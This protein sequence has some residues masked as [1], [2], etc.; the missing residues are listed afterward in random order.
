M[1]TGQPDALAPLRDAL[2]STGYEVDLRCGPAGMAD[3]DLAIVDATDPEHWSAAELLAGG[4]LILMVQDARDMR[5]GF[6][7]GA[8]DCVLREAHPDELAARCD[9]VIRRTERPQPERGRPAVYVDRRLW[10]NFGS[11]QVWVS[12]TPVHLTPREFRL[13]RYLVRHSGETLSHG[14]ILEAVWSRSESSDRPTEV[15][16]Q[17]IWRLRQKLE[18]DPNEPDTIITDA[19]RGYRFVGHTV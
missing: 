2:E 10:I 18:P 12:G 13:L 6:E 17:Y 4:R 16:K 5:R 3:A 1:L 9:A 7:V 11:R 14:E 8:D 19:G 15:L